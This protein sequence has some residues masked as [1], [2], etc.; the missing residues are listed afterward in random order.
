[1]VLD[2]VGVSRGRHGGVVRQVLSDRG[3]DAGQRPA[4]FK[5]W[6]L[7]AGQDSVT[8]TFSTGF[9][10]VALQLV[11]GPD[12]LVGTAHDF[13]DFGPSSRVAS[14]TLR[15]IACEGIEIRVRDRAT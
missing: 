10:G 14:A 1:M 12:S 4:R 5:S 11:N 15:K 6:E 13:W 3:S 2:S 8:V 9:S 7:A